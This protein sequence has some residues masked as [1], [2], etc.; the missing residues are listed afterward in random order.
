MG[1]ELLLLDEK[2]LATKYRCTVSGRLPKGA[3]DAI[4]LK[5]DGISRDSVNRYCASA[6]KQEEA[7][8]LSIELNSKKKGKPEEKLSS[9]KPS[10]MFVARQGKDKSRLRKF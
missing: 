1:K 10:K 7:G 2:L 4:C 6:R 9:P 8:I 5:F 3:L